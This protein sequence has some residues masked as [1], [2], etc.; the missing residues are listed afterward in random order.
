M[1][2]H[3]V[4]CH[5][6]HGTGVLLVEDEPCEAQITVG[7]EIITCWAVRPHGDNPHMALLCEPCSECGG[8]DDHAEGCN[9][10][11]KVGPGEYPQHWCSWHNQNSTLIVASEEY[12][13]DWRSKYMAP[14]V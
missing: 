1:A 14:V 7:H 8:Y 9:R 3:K 10:I 5:S 12:A 2:L 13:A 11:G 6:C 4:P